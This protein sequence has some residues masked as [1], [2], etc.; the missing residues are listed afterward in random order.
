[1]QTQSA[2]ATS[3]AP[4]AWRTNEPPA[5]PGS[6]G[7]PATQHG[8]FSN[9]TSVVVARDRKGIWSVGIIAGCYDR[10][11]LRRPRG[12]RRRADPARSVALRPDVSN[13]VMADL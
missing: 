10:G 1:M 3:P 13:L 11:S 2:S 5:F 9:R 6:I 8:I 7:Q 12:G 4:R